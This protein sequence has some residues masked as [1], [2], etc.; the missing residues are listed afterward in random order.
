MYHYAHFIDKSEWSF[1]E[2]QKLLVSITIVQWGGRSSEILSGEHRVTELI[3]SPGTTDGQARSVPMPGQ[4]FCTHY[5]QHAVLPDGTCE[6]GT[7]INVLN[8]ARKE[9]LS[10]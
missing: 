6:V 9:S 4:A 8:R 5:I 3:L 7:C 10:S 1:A 2:V